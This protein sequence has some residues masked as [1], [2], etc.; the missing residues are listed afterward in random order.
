MLTYFGAWESLE[1]CQTL[2]TIFTLQVNRH[3]NHYCALVAWCVEW[4]LNEFPDWHIQVVLS[5]QALHVVL[6]HLVFL[7]NLFYLELQVD[8]VTLVHPVDKTKKGDLDLRTCKH[9][10][11]S[12]ELRDTSILKHTENTGEI[13]F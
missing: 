13:K 4:V 6:D 11:F 1:T 12:V 5:D 3:D 2:I 7:C 9:I 8:Q 10:D